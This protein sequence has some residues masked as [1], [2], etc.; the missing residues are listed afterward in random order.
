MSEFLAGDARIDPKLGLK[1]CEKT[2]CQLQS[3]C[4]VGELVQRQQSSSASDQDLT[5][6]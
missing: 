3:L 5:A 2:Y 1:T 6:P 4:R